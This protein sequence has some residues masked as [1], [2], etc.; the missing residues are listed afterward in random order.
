M[1]VAGTPLEGAEPPGPLDIVRCVAAARVLMPRSVVRL[2]AGRLKL[3]KTDQA[4]SQHR[5]HTT[6]LVCCSWFM[7]HSKSDACSSD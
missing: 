7:M 6:I 5:R 4:R 2:S 1:A 3:S